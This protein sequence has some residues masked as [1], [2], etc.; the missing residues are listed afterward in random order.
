M[1]FPFR[2]D[3]QDGLDAFFLFDTMNGINRMFVLFIR[4]SFGWEM[5]GVA[6]PFV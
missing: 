3:E 4:V 2:L 5:L 6:L 1:S